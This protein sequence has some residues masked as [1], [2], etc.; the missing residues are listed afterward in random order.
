MFLRKSH[1]DSTKKS[2][3]LLF[4]RL[5]YI[6]DYNLVNSVKYTKIVNGRII[7]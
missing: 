6:F 5:Y 2:E 4:L 1:T 3:T 7:H